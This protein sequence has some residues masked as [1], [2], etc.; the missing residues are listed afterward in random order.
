M[1][2]RG[3]ARILGLGRELPVF[4]ARQRRHGHRAPAAFVL[5]RL[6]LADRRL[7]GARGKRAAVLGARGVVGD[8]CWG[9]GRRASSPV[10]LSLLGP[11][12]DGT[13]CPYAR[14]AG[15]PRPPYAEQFSTT[16]NA[17]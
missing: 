14:R 2:R 7:R 15:T 3:H 10:A 11:G 16:S 6:A 12:Q 5:A 17:P 13:P 1:V 4:R 9:D 8:I